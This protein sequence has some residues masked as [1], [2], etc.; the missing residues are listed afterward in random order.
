MKTNKFSNKPFVFYYYV[1]LIISNLMVL[2]NPQVRTTLESQH[3]KHLLI[4]P[5]TLTSDAVQLMGAGQQALYI[6]T[7]EISY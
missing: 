1:D 5:V 3:V 7:F 4:M 6:N 2:T